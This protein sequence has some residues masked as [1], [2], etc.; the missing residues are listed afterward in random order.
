MVIRGGGIAAAFLRHL[1]QQA[2]IQATF[3]PSPKR[4]VP[5]LLIGARAQAL[6]QGLFPDKNVFVG[7]PRLESRI[8]LWGSAKEPIQLPHD[9]LVASEHEL[10][11]RLHSYVAQEREQQGDADWSLFTSLPLP[12]PSVERRFGQRFA[13]VTAV[14]LCDRAER[15]ACWIESARDGWLFLLPDREKNGWLLTVGGP[16]SRMLSHSRLVAE[17]VDS[18]VGLES[19]F[20]A[21]PAISDPLCGPGWLACGRAALAFDP[22]CG[23]GVGNAVREAILASAVVRAA[24]MDENQAALLLHYESRLLSGFL[25]HLG[26]SRSFYGYDVEGPWWREETKLLDQGI[27]FCRQRLEKLGPPRFRLSGFDLIPV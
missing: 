23:D 22:L 26:I 4:G 1:L 11:E 12:E 5:A 7:L 13:S 18:T 19:T 20:P 14:R 8:V 3:E 2:R 27:G 16:Q 21:S 15:S 24:L 6:M 9:A 25:K 10:S 17:R